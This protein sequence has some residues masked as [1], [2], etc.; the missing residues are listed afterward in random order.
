M[1]LDNLPKLHTRQH[2]LGPAVAFLTSHSLP[3]FSDTVMVAVCPGRKTTMPTRH[4]Q[5]GLTSVHEIDKAAQVV[6]SLQLEKLLKE[7]VS[8][9]SAMS[10][11]ELFINFKV[12]H[13]GVV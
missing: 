13:G 12:L 1:K 8:T 4:L 9:A 10:E 11:V 5:A 2:L 7:T 3:T 6:L